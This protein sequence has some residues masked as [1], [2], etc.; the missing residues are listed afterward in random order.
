M[1]AIIYSISTYIIGSL[2]RLLVYI[3]GMDNKKHVFRV[4]CSQ[5]GLQL[6]KHIVH[7]DEAVDDQAHDAHLDVHLYN[8]LLDLL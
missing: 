7:A 4:F 3:V 8:V 2:H 5:L 1:E 6:K